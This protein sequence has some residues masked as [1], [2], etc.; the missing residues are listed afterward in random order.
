MCEVTP[1]ADLSLTHGVKYTKKF[2]KK[3]NKKHTAN[4][5][6]VLDRENEIAKLLSSKKV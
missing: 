3:N 2:F 6:A 4:K 5:F 1:D